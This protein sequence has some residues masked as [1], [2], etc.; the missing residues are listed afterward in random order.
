MSSPLIGRNAV[1]LKGTTEIGY[2]T[3]VTTSIDSDLIKEYAMGDDKPVVLAA[4]NK[5]FSIDIEKMYIDNAYAQDVLNGS[6]VTIE[7]RPQG[8]GSGKPKITLSDVV[9]NSWELSIEQDGV[10][11]ESVSGEG[12]SIAFGTQT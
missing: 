8:T 10:I 9:L 4:G 6:T 1:V 7:I 3:G 11:M 5:T 2:C 12:K